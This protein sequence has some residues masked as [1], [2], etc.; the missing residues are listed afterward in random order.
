[1][2]A[3]VVLEQTTLSIRVKSKVNDTTREE[4]RWFARLGIFGVSDNQTGVDHVERAD[5]ERGGGDLS[6][7]V[8]TRF[9]LDAV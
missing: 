2:F 9:A 5:L 6:G 1:M 4:R 3:R 7:D 8:G